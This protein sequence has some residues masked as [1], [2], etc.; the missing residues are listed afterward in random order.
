MSNS[1]IAKMAVLAVRAKTK[2]KQRGTR[3]VCDLSFDEIYAMAFVL[4]AFFVDYD[5]PLTR[6]DPAH[7]TPT[8]ELETA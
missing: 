6:G 1:E 4:D 8:Q 3:G 7:S 5:G 2:V